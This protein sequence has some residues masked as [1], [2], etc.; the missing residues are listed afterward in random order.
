MDGDAADLPALA[1]LKQ[2]AGTSP[3]LLVVDEAHG[4]GVYGP[5]GAGLAAEL[6]LSAA[7]DVTV[8]TLSKAVGVGGA[9]VCGSRAFC[10]VLVNLGRAYV[11]ST[12]VPPMVAAAAEASVGVMRDEPERQRRVR[13]LARRVRA[14]LSTAGFAL[15]PGDSPIIPLV[16]GDERAALSAADRLADRG[17]LALAIRPPT[18]ARGTSRLRVTLSSEHSDG[19]VDHLLAALAD[20]RRPELLTE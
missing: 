3:P 12:S 7:V 8:V 14:E 5:G 17:L 9:A 20:L 10:D 4:S 1:S 19:Q 18:V 6:G 13:A 11:F 15:P 2:S 16:L